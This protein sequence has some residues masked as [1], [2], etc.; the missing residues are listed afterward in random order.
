ML[1]HSRRAYR[2]AGASLAFAATALLPVAVAAAPKVALGTLTCK[3]RGNVSLILGSK[4]VMHCVFATAISGK[5][6]PYMA[7][8]TKVGLDLGYK[9]SSTFIWTVLGPTLEV[10]DEALA[11]N[12]GGL[13][14]GM[15]IGYGGSA[16]ALVGGFSKSIF[17]QPLSVEGQSGFNLSAG[18]A[19]L[20]LEPS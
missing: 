10:P 7:T 20:L 3:G 9:N 18:V 14:A 4:E 11:G 5:H 12:Y 6:Y 2:L 15:S 13:T 1:R 16:N 19:G 17:L 8:I